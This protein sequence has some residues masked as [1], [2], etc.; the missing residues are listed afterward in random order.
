MKFNEMVYIH[1][2]YEE[3]KEQMDPLLD[4]LEKAKDSTSFM[5]IFNRINVLRQHFR[6]MESLC[7]IRYTIDTSDEY[8]SKEHE[9]WNE[10][11]PRLQVFEN[12]L[13]KIVLT[14]PHRE[15][16]PI[17]SVYFEM[18]ENALKCFSEDII[19][20]LQK[21]NK[22][23]SEYSRLRANAKV[24]FKGETYTLS[25]ISKFFKNAD[26]EI[27][28]EAYLTAFGVYESLE[29]EIDRIYDELVHLRTSMAHKLGFDSF[30][31][32]GYL[33]MN[34]IGYNREMVSNLR[35][36][37]IREVVP[38]VKKIMERQA[39]RLGLDTLYA[40]DEGYEFTTGNPVPHGT[41]DELVEAAMAMYSEMS[42]ETKE[43]FAFMKENELF[44]LV[45]KPN[46]EMGGYCT[47]IDEYKAPFIF[48]NF[49][50]TS[51][52]VNVLT[53]EA[54]HAFQCYS[55]LK[56]IDIPDCLW[57]TYESCEIHSMSM[58]FFAYPW[59]DKFFK[60][61]ANKYK[62]S[63]IASTLAF[64]PYGCLVDHF[65]HEV[66]DHPDWTPDERKQCYHKLEKMYIPTRDYGEA[67]FLKKGTY[68][69]RQG[70]IFFAPF[71]YIDYV[72][73]QVCALEFFDTLKKDRTVAWNN[74]VELCK[75]GGTKPFLGLIEAAHLVSPFEKGALH[76][77]VMSAAQDLDSIDDSKY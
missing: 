70:H 54:G 7:S 61:D 56:T 26:R 14:Y 1:L 31:E 62:Y 69:Y 60:E 71:Y 42:E 5:E 74:Y 65:Q 48:S 4:E 63:H 51:G 59:L 29:K 13:S 66:Y 77:A 57:P 18:N 37:I 2:S 35:E 45:A 30:V 43:F 24:N 55:S 46:K 17:P 36:E 47:T 64:L 34:R 58:E 10:T 12:R 8:Y 16:L 9:Y 44:D 33:R 27:R 41:P 25:E 76:D 49:N 22:L 73:A 20:D 67:E 39:K 75:L 40:Y 3:I 28:R 38:Q 32:L 11:T 6:S 52:D 72:I 23:S 19:E 21:E 15:E 53:H 68:W 50:G